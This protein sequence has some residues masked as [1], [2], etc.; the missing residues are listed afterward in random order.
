MYILLKCLGHSVFRKDLLTGLSYYDVPR[1]LVTW[2]EV[3]R[4]V[5]TADEM[6][7]YNFTTL[8]RPVAC[9]TYVQ[10]VQ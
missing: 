3:P 4:H 9:R 6:P 10:V 5:V 8:L 1:A 2:R 7:L